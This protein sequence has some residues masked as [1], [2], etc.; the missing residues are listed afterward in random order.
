MTDSEWETGNTMVT[1]LEVLP[2]C[3][4]NKTLVFYSFSKDEPGELKV[5]H[6]DSLGNGDIFGKIKSHINQ[7][8]ISTILLAI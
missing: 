4:Y 3:T 5:C 2:S 1:Q 8:I 7:Y 6:M